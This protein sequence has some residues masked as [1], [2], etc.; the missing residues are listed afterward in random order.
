[1]KL[2][3]PIERPASADGGRWLVDLINTQIR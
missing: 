3:P 2:V 1:V